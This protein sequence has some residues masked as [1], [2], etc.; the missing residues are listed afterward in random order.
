MKK[1]SRDEMK[2]VVGGNQ[3][4][5]APGEGGTGC[6]KCCRGNG[7]CS[8]CSFSYAGAQCPESGNTL[9]SCSGC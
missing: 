1:L 6:Y 5:S 3:D 2:N 7:V 8:S 4:E 9:T